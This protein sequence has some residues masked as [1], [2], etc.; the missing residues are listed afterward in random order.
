MNM[1]L[2]SDVVTYSIQLALVVSIGAV[3]AKLVRID[4]PGVRFVYWRTLLAVC[5]ALPWLQVRQP[6]DAPVSPVPPI[7]LSS[8]EPVVAAA[9]SVA[10][11]PAFSI[12]WLSVA[13]WVLVAGIAFRLARIGVGLW[14]LRRLRVSGYVAPACD[15]HEEAQWVA[16][17]Q[18]EIRY[19]PHGQPVTFGFLRPVVLL[20]EMLRTQSADV[21]RVVLYHELFHVRRRDWIWAVSEEIVKAVLWFHPAVWWLISRVQLA[22]EEVVDEL[23][24]LA[25]SKRRAYIEALL[26]FADA[27]VQAPAAA[28]ARRRDLLRR[29]VLI[30]KEA[31]MSSRRIVLSAA[32]M[33]ALV[34]A[35]G[36]CV[37]TTFPLTE[38][39][40]AQG[41]GSSAGAAASFSASQPG[42]LE[43]QA[44]P[45][46]PENPIPRR[47]FSV[48]PQNPSDDT[49]G[50]VIVSVRVVVDRQGRVAEA[51]GAGEFAIGG[52]GSSPAVAPPSNLFEKAVLDAVRQWQYDPPADG[53]IAFDVA[54]QFAQG[55]EPR[56]MSHGQAPTIR[57]APPPPPPPPPPPVA[58]GGAPGLPAAP[59]PVPPAPP[60]GPV[61]GGLP[62]APP[63]PPP[64]PPPPGWGVG[65]VRVGGAVHVPQKIKHVGP[66]YPPIAQSAR[67]Q[68]V[69]IV[70]ALVG[71]DGRVEDVRVLRSIPLLDQAAIDAV[72]QWEFQPTL[73]NGSPVAI[74]MTATVQFTLS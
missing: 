66:V 72:R 47:T 64:P 49:T 57:L 16:R 26:V 69:V 33:A 40:S 31:V 68:G 7:T 52:R 32:A 43:R 41:R 19:V 45:I 13:G 35:S 65:A 58:R 25:T 73:L 70:E 37:V 22:R 42:T 34:A 29:M 10:A 53:P 71:P 56:L 17:A 30:S 9:Q 2:L 61:L 51:R 18:A 36:W 4:A 15:A 44:K 27:P 20:P 59:P 5:L 21:E 8:S 38:I 12:D 28:F 60:V 11:A 54:F 63:P 50:V 3:V 74:L 24:V 6:I 48:T 62:L 39:V 1:G 14:R 23:T 67:V 46:T 55:S